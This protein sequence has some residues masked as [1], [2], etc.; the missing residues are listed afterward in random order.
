MA[1]L[2]KYQQTK[3]MLNNGIFYLKIVANDTFFKKKAHR[4]SRKQ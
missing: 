3:Q 2:L 1:A 4:A